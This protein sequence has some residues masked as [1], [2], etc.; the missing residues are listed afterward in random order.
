MALPV[1]EAMSG[2]GE[3]TRLMNATMPTKVNA[4]LVIALAVFSAGTELQ[5]AV[6]HVSGDAP[7]GGDGS[8]TRPFRTLYEAVAAARKMPGPN[9]IVVADGRYFFDR[10]LSLNARDSGLAIR[11]AHPARRIGVLVVKKGKA[12]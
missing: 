2:G 11:A 3:V 6:S 1:A 5:G 12:E 7:Q 9:E 10:T 4:I 8:E